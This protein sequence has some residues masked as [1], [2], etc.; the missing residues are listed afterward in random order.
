MFSSSSS[1]S[2]S[3]FPPPPKPR[4]RP[5]SPRAGRRRCPPVP[6]RRSQHIRLP[7]RRQGSPPPSPSPRPPPPN[8]PPPPSQDC[9]GSSIREQHP[10]HRSTEAGAG[11]SQHPGL[12]LRGATPS[13]SSRCGS[14]SE[15][16]GAGSG[17]G[18]GSAQS[19]PPSHP[20]ARREYSAAT[21][22][23][24]ASLLPL[25]ARAARS[26][27]SEDLPDLSAWDI[28]SATSDGSVGSPLAAAEAEMRTR[29][30]ERTRTARS[31]GGAGGPGCALI[32]RLP[33]GGGD[34]P[35]SAG[36][37]RW[38]KIWVER[39]SRESQNL[40]EGK[41]EEEWEGWAGPDMRDS[42]PCRGSSNQEEPGCRS[43]YNINFHGKAYPPTYTF[44]MT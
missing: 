7:S 15:S 11:A 16:G 40:R 22:L 30:R 26:R 39:E 6:G 44:R 19:L 5:T 38:G 37:E 3:S 13:R 1:S 43:V 8:G 27:A 41:E 36:S 33:G 29:T 20:S 34:G 31:E 12:S 4:R 32:C 28:G 14:E 35:G 2:S 42:L 23:L 9:G 18:S 10:S 21:S 17:S 25:Q 24:L